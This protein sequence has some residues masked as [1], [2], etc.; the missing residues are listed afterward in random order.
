MPAG[1]EAGEAVLDSL[2]VKRP[3][4]VSWLRNELFTGDLV[5]ALEHDNVI[6]KALLDRFGGW[7]LA[8]DTKLDALAEL[9]AVTHADEKILVFTEYADTAAYVV[10]ALELRGIQGI[11]LATGDS[12]NPTLLARRFSPRSN[13]EIGGLPDGYA[14]LRIL[15][16]TDVLSEGQNLQD[17][18]IVVNFDLPWAIIRL[19]QR[20]GRVD[21]IGQQSPTVL[22]YSFLPE[23]GVEAVINLRQR[24]A[25]RLQA[26]ASVFGSDERFLNTPG[27]AH[28]IERLFDENAEFPDEQDDDAENVD[29][30]SA[31]YEIW[32]HAEE[33]HPTL[34]EAAR[35]LPAVTYATRNANEGETE[36]VVVYTMT[37]HGF[38]RLVAQVAGGPVTRLSPMQALALTRCDPE[39]PG[40][41]ALPEHHAMVRSS[42][43]YSVQHDELGTEGNL[44]GIRRRLYERLRDAT[45]GTNAQLF[46]TG[47][48]LDDALEAIYRFPL[49]EQAKQSLARALRERSIDDVSL[50]VLQLHEEGILTIDTSGREDEVQIVCSMGVRVTA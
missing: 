10:E 8:Q 30:S 15:V 31:A 19:I 4:G 40:L 1:L 25:G 29:Y 47:P 46:G 3:A 34:A 38:D 5:E 7:D 13:A 9:L 6:L 24:I 42:V 12:D 28:V 14:E 18:A 21:R 45:I 26:S 23:E 32:R 17:A 44:T 48:Q 33:T 39:A 27:E 49:T 36:G 20:A 37:T 50:L 35:N 16:A 11:G 22:V 43:E 2:L 41:P